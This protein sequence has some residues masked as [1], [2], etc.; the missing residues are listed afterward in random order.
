MRDGRDVGKRFI[1]ASRDKH[2]IAALEEAGGEGRPVEVETAADGRA[3]F[4]FCAA[5]PA[6]AKARL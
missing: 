2:T 4:R 5:A 1:A 3:T 6:P